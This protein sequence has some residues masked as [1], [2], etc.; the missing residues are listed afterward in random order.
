M[1]QIR[2]RVYEKANFDLVRSLVLHD[3]RTADAIN[4]RMRLL[5]YSVNDN[6]PE[7]WKYYL[8]LA[9]KPHQYDT[10]KIV[11]ATGY[12]LLKVK[13]L[14]M[15]TVIDFTPENLKVHKSTLKAYRPGSKLYRALTYTYPELIGYIRGVVRPVSYDKASSAGLYEILSYDPALVETNETGLIDKINDWIGKAV[16]RFDSNIFHALEAGFT[17]GLLGILFAMLP[18]VVDNIRC[19]AQFTEQAHSFHVKSFLASNGNLDKYYDFL[20][21]KQR[22]YLYRNLRYIRRHVGEQRIFDGLVDVLMTDAGHAVLGYEV[23]QDDSADEADGV[24]FVRKSLNGIDAVNGDNLKTPEEME[25]LIADAAPNNILESDVDLEKIKS[26]PV[27]SPDSVQVT[28]VIECNALVTGDEIPFRLYDLLFSEWVYLSHVTVNGITPIYASTVQFENPATNESF[29]LKASDAFFLFIYSYF[30]GKGVRLTELPPIAVDLVPKLS[31]PTKAQLIARSPAYQS[32][33]EDIDAILAAGVPSLDIFGIEDFFAYTQDVMK[34]AITRQRVIDGCLHPSYRAMISD[35]VQQCY[36]T[37]ALPASGVTYESWFKSKGLEFDNLDDAGFEL[38]ANELFDK[39]TGYGDYATKDPAKVHE[40]LTNLL[41]DLS[42]YNVLFARTTNDGIRAKIETG[43]LLGVSASSGLGYTESGTLPVL[44]TAVEIENLESPVDSRLQFETGLTGS[45]SHSS[46]GILGMRGKI[47]RSNETFSEGEIQLS[48][49]VHTPVTDLG[50]PQGDADVVYPEIA[51]LSVVLPLATNPTVKLVVQDVLGTSE[52]VPLSTMVSRATDTELW[53]Y[54]A[55]SV[56]TTTESPTEVGISV[57]LDR[58]NLPVKYAGI[59]G[60]ETFYYERLN[61]SAL[62]VDRAVTRVKVKLPISSV[63]LAA[64]LSKAS[65]LRI[66]SDDL[67]EFDYTS[68][69]NNLIEVSPVS[70]HYY[71]S[72]IVELAEL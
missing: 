56:V 16:Y 49:Y 21:E 25:T 14:D 57:E 71:N 69:G 68:Y 4:R 51:E 44:P 30:A 31:P 67:L 24:V 63:D 1:A 45:T 41:K 72:P 50:V 23:R 59:T 66:Q 54:L 55:Y 18:A 15:D 52:F 29:A 6:D 11:A 48:G 53:K 28:K 8:N 35:A 33:E 3:P 70:R 26:L 37:F 12:S 62:F 32:L 65:G 20:T 17:P 5:G 42:S 40:A 61:L 27:A 47:E 10:D 19:A 34:S 7:S 58:L 43:F 36:C 39:S 64:V 2:F 46:I 60:M 13:S 38:L 22:M 9:G